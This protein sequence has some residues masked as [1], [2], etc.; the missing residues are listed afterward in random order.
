M[1]SKVISLEQIEF[2]PD[3]PRLTFADESINEL[4][5]SLKRD[6]LIQPIVVRPKGA[7]YELVVGERRVRAAIRANIP[8]L[9]AIIREDMTDEEASRLRLI[10]NINRKDLTVFEKARGMKSHMEKYGFTLEQIAK[11]IHKSPQTV[12]NWIHT[13]ESTSPKIKIIDEFVRK[14]GTYNLLMLTKYNDE[15]QE[16]LARKIVE[17][18]MSQNQVDRFL[19]LFDSN[20]EVALDTLVEKAIGQVKVVEVEM[21][22]EEAEKYLKEKET[23]RK[24]AR[25]KLE[26]HLRKPRER[27]RKSEA[28]PESKI[29]KV[30]VIYK[31]PDTQKLWDTALAKEV[32][33]AGLT[34]KEV[35][36]LKKFERYVPIGQIRL[37]EFSTKAHELVE[38]VIKETR[39]QIVVLEVPPKLYKAIEDFA[40]SERIF[41]KDA[42]LALV[43]EC[44]ERRGFWTR[45]VIP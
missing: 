34:A 8:K 32:E 18:N 45:E 16:K 14:L 30:D 3:N 13:A 15:T 6:G 26:K 20:P 38:K 10:E 19:R 2:R 11:T 44:L 27:K 42:V 7:K 41:V 24:K 28:K 39:P 37:E 40:N 4:V 31:E 21:P 5:A 36:L 17:N 43:E 12:K 33:K 1:K 35:E 29:T 25:K 22:V 9:Q 23:R